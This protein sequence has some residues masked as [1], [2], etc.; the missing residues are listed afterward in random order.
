MSARTTDELLFRDE[1]A[2]LGRRLDLRVIE[3]VSAPPPDWTGVTGR[4]DE[5]LLDRVL[6]DEDL[7]EV[8]ALIC[9][10]GPMMRDVKTALAALGLDPGQI[11]TEEFDMV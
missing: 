11:Q 7:V 2:E 9:A 3:V 6:F 1:L 4:I 10:S 8:E 5:D